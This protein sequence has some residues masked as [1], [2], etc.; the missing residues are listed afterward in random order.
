MHSSTCNTVSGK[1][2]SENVQLDEM[3]FSIFA[4]FIRRHLCHQQSSLHRKEN[5]PEENTATVAYIRQLSG[6]AA[7]DMYAIIYYILYINGIQ[8]VYH[9][10]MFFKWYFILFDLIQDY[11]FCF[12]FTAVLRLNISRYFANTYTPEI[13]I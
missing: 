10:Y 11:A 12:Y 1:H 5:K 3:N 4:K 6:F 8:N 13:A 2:K 7:S 9:L